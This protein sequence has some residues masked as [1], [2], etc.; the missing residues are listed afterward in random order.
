[1]YWLQRLQLVSGLTI[2]I[3]HL[4]YLLGFYVLP[5]ALRQLSSCEIHDNLLLLRHNL[6]L[7]RHSFPLLRHNHPL[8]QHKVSGAVEI[9]TF[10]IDFRPYCWK[11]QL[12]VW[13]WKRLLCVLRRSNSFLWLTS[14]RVD[15]SGTPSNHLSDSG[16]PP[17]GVPPQCS[18]PIYASQQRCS[19]T[20]G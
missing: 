7:L 13:G 4:R 15:L 18:S 6:P 5:H 14:S 8:L 20:L 2:R 17:C 16:A 9:S 19:D 3:M 11:C 10:R 12:L 1:M